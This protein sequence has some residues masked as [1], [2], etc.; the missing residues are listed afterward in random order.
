LN[1]KAIDIYKILKYLPH[2][3]PFMMIDK[4]KTW[5]AEKSLHAVKNITFNEPQFTGHF[6]EQPVMPGVMMIEAMAQACGLLTY[7]TLGRLPAENE[8]NYLVGIDN[9]RFKQIVKP[10]DVMHIH[11]EMIRG[12]RGIYK[13]KGRVT[14][15]DEVAAEADIMNATM[16]VEKSD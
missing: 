5:E 12:K 2:R 6:P 9:A 15:N 7:L 1:E 3:Y 4:V 11:V 10:G 8:A 14:V 16:V 13:F